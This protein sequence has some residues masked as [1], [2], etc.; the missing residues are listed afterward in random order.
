MRLSGW[1]SMKVLCSQGAVG[2]HLW[3]SSHVR[4]LRRRLHLRRHGASSTCGS[5][6]A[7]GRIWYGL[8]PLSFMHFHAVLLGNQHEMW[9]KQH[10]G[11][12]SRSLRVGRCDEFLERGQKLIHLGSIGVTS[13]TLEG[14]HGSRNL[15]QH[16][17]ILLICPVL[18]DPEIAN[19]RL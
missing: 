9:S 15:L 1:Y 4:P 19:E 12:V 16:G 7:F 18:L 3:G 6:K 14:L 13:L 11:K 8:K 5:R 17:R 2:P 10:N